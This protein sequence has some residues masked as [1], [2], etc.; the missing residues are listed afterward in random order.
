M[1]IRGPVHSGR[2]TRRTGTEFSFQQNRA[3]AIAYESDEEA[4]WDEEASFDSD[5]PDGYEDGYQEDE[6]DESVDDDAFASSDLYQSSYAAGASTDESA[7]DE[8]DDYALEQAADNEAEENEEGWDAEGDEPISEERALVLA[9]NGP[10]GR[11]WAAGTGSNEVVVY[12][13]LGSTAPVFIAGSGKITVPGML[14]HVPL[15]P[16][17]A[18]PRPFYMHS[19]LFGVLVVS[20]VVAGVALIPLS[21]R[22]TLLNAFTSWAGVIA[23]P[24]APAV[25][26][27]N[28]IVHYGD[29]L[30]SIASKFG[31]PPGGILEI[32]N[33]ASGDQLFLGFKIKIPLDSQ[34]GADFHPL[35]NI[36]LAPTNTPDPPYG[37]GILVQGFSSFGVSDYFGDPWA[38]SFG[39]CTWWAAH[40]R[41]DENF[42][43]IGDAWTWANGARARGYTVTADPVVNATVAFD[44]GV[45]FAGGIGHVAHVEQILSNGWIL[46]SEMNFFGNNGGWGRVDYRYITPGPGVWFIH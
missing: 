34:Y 4:A 42:A 45:E 8:D 6:Y 39:Q 33:L 21:G 28:Y 41:P 18:R 27:Q 38:G 30:D 2:L 13:E 20:L 35:L 43:G 29:T 40:K 15:A 12:Q 36:P 24:Q 22:Q 37:Y 46:I 11:R 7:F 16:R 25:R 19:F 32:N 31:V 26:F 17:A 5:T 3:G 10:S 14:G 23:P 1:L 44:A 9:G